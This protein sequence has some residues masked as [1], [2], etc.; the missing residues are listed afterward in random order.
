MKRFLYLLFFCFFLFN[1]FALDENQLGASPSETG[2]IDNC[3][4]ELIAQDAV[5]ENPKN[6]LKLMEYKLKPYTYE[7]KNHP[8]TEENKENTN[9][10][11][12]KSQETK[13]PIEDEKT[14][15]PDICTQNLENNHKTVNDESNS[16][17]AETKKQMPDENKAV[18]ED[19]KTS[20][21]SKAAIADDNKDGVN[22][23]YSKS[24]H[25]NLPVKDDKPKEPE[26]CTQNLENNH[27]TVK[28]E[29]NSSAAETKK[30]MP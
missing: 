8:I 23:A 7:T 27:K 2:T 30:Q 10:A 9:I 28:D 16:S 20:I 25:I 6:Q 24:Q 22:T 1:A 29:S 5:L 18:L 12:T 19:Q 15:E 14:N 11:E 26:T 13:L 21:E 3:S 17:A 4:N